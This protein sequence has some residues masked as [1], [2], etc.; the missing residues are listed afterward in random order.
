MTNQR[1]GQVK[2]CYD[3]SEDGIPNFCIDLIDGTRLY[4][5]GEMLNPLPEKGN[6]ISYNIINTKESKNG[7]PYSNVSSVKVIDGNAPE[8]NTSVSS[9]G[10]SK[11]STQ[12][13]D[14]FVTG[15][16]GRAMGS[17]Q[18]SV[19]DIPELTKKAVQ[20]FNENLKEL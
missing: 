1:T 20:S 15:V 17:G 3:N 11:S 9:G 16:V 14:I 2:A 6:T 4:S 12:R 13:L 18:Y 19:A 8:A 5:R 10:N 7:N